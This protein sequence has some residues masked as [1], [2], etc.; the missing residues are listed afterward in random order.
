[1][2]LAAPPLL[3]RLRARPVRTARAKCP[4]TISWLAQGRFSPDPASDFYN[5]YPVDIDLCQRF[6]INGIRVSIAWSRI[7]PNGTGEINPE[8]VAFYHE[9]F[10][11]CNKAG[12]IPYVTLDHF[13]TPE[14]FYQ[15]GGEG[16]LTRT[17]IDA[18]VEYA[19]FCFAEFTEV[20]HWFTFNEIPATAEG[21]F[22]VGNLAARREVSPGQGL[23]AHAQ[24]DGGPRQGCRRLP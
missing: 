7:F 20:K 14:A 3:T 9:L 17:T 24:H 4:G 18:F 13:D 15:N 19:K 10:A 12:V 6:G 1:M 11:T 22:I 16:F 21:S 8:G 5:K 2:C 23:P